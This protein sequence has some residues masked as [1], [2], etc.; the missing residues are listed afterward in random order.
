MA[1]EEG[2]EDIREIIP[3]EEIEAEDSEAEGH[4]V[5]AEAAGEPGQRKKLSSNILTP[6]EMEN[7]LIEI[8]GKVPSFVINDIRENLKDK[9]LNGEKLSNIIS[10]V[11]NAYHMS[12]GGASGGGA[13]NFTD[14]IG[15]FSQHLEELTREVKEIKSGKPQPRVNTSPKPPKVEKKVKRIEELSSMKPEEFLFVSGDGDGDDE[16]RLK[17]IP[18]D[19]FSIMI[20][21]KW[22]EL[23]VEKVGITNLPDVLEFYCD[24]EWISD[25][26][27]AKLIKYAKGTKPFHEDV[28]WKPEEKLTA[29]DHMLS[30]LFVERLRGKQVSKDLLIQLDRELKKIRSGAEE[31]YGI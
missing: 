29:R 4:Q 10:R 12:K 19:V 3:L 20:T 24:M 14:I 6:E 31:I 16:V 7:K 18:D 17:S 2:K 11:V 30:L 22:I 25:A 8:R 5:G 23:M 28:D 1:M 9:T 21:M 26:V 13:G 27:V 15:K